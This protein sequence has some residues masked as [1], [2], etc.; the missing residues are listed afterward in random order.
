MRDSASEIRFYFAAPKWWTVLD[1]N[2]MHWLA[3]QLAASF[4]AAL[5]ESTSLP[6]SA[7]GQSASPTCRAARV[8]SFLELVA[9]IPVAFIH[10]E[11][12]VLLQDRSSQQPSSYYFHRLV[13]PRVD[14]GD[15]RFD[16]ACWIG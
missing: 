8:L 4:P 10:C 15:V 2:F 7:R 14:I 1:E 6:S 12:V 16:D 13:H 9:W 5:R 3:C 11:S